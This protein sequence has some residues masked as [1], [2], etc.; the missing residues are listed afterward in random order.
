MI[1]SLNPDPFN[2]SR[3]LHRCGL[4]LAMVAWVQ[5]LAAQ[6]AEAVL[7]VE[8]AQVRNANGGLGCQLFA[9]ADG[10]PLRGERALQ[11]LMVPIQNGS[12]RCRFLPVQAG[13]YAVAILHDEN[14]NQKLDSNLLGMPTEGYGVSNNKTY[15]LSQP[16]WEESRFDLA[17]GETRQL[18]IQL[19]Y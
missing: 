14:G 11:S 5:P 18:T 19:R 9:S 3:I 7:E 6:N 12:A 16:R 17:P 15:A 2:P 4:M 10:F 13:T 1:N 8:V